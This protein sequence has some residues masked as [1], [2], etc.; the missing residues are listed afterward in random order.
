MFMFLL[1][2]RL[3]VLMPLLFFVFLFVVMLRVPRGNIPF[4]VGLTS[5]NFNGSVR[6][7]GVRSHSLG[8]AIIRSSSQHINIIAT[9][10]GNF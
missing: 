3:S 7:L 4:Q 5:L 6:R 2:A 1:L 10:L 8:F 9:S